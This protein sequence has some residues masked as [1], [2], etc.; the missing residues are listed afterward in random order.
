VAADASASSPAGATDA[1]AGTVA[2]TT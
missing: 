2:S 1:A